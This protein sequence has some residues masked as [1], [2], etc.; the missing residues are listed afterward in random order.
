[1]GTLTR[2]PGGACTWAWYGVFAFGYTSYVFADKRSLGVL[3]RSYAGLL[4][5]RF[6]CFLPVVFD[7]VNVDVRNYC[8]RL[9]AGIVQEIKE[10]KDTHTMM[11]AGLQEK[12]KAAVAT[13]EAEAEASITARFEP[14]LSDHVSFC[15]CFFVLRIHL[16]LGVPTAAR[17]NRQTHEQE[18]GKALVADIAIHPAPIHTCVAAPRLLAVQLAQ[19]YVTRFSFQKP[20]LHERAVCQSL[21]L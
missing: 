6:S 8:S 21:P 20:K 17:A 9:E 13:V 7:D 15:V 18:E 19:N 5:R 10:R 12:L 14:G 4:L 3:G 11:F 2:E 1:M 16:F